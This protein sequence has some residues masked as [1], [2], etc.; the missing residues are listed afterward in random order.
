MPFKKI[1]LIAIPF[2]L[3]AAWHYS[4]DKPYDKKADENQPVQI[5]SVN[6]KIRTSDSKFSTSS[7]LGSSS[8]SN[9]ISVQAEVKPI[10]NEDPLNTYLLATNNAASLA[11]KIKS[12]P[13]LN[14]SKAAQTVYDSEP[15][16]A[17]WAET[18]IQKLQDTFSNTPELQN[19]NLKSIDC[20]SK[21]CQ[22][23]IFYKDKSEL[24]P[25]VQQLA[26]SS[27]N[28]NLKGLFIPSAQ[29]IYSEDGTTGII[30]LSDD[31]NAKLD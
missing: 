19:L 17:E 31:R 30:Y 5:T 8:S 9:N 21:F 22:I 3:F 4:P 2:L 13:T 18:R 10:S 16:V 12:D 26:M 23:Q 24:G 1:S 27:I 15:Y 7:S 11:D 29:I 25:V 20:K 6:Q 28:G 14:V